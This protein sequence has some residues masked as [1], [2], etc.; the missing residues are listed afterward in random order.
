VR[1]CPLNPRPGQEAIRNGKKGNCPLNLHY[2]K[3]YRLCQDLFLNSAFIL[4]LSK[5]NLN[6][7]SCFAFS[8]PA[9][10][11]PLLDQQQLLGLLQIARLQASQVDARGQ[12]RPIEADL[13]RAGGIPA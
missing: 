11:S 7:N 4:A 9:Q 8:L 12:A 10:C 1:P 2:N 13:V 5:L 3:K 6:A